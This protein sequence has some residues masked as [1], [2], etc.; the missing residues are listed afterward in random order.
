[1]ALVCAEFATNL[2]QTAE[3]PRTP[4]VASKGPMF[5]VPQPADSLRVPSGPATAAP[6]LV[7]S[8]PSTT[9]VLTHLSLG[10]NVYVD[11]HRLLTQPCI[12]TVPTLGFGTVVFWNGP[13]EVHA[14]RPHGP[15]QWV[16]VREVV[17]TLARFEAS[18][19]LQ[20]P[21]RVG[22]AVNVAAVVNAIV[23]GKASMKQLIVGQEA[24]FQSAQLFVK[25][26]INHASWVVKQHQAATTEVE[27]GPDH[28]AVPKALQDAWRVCCHAFGCS[29]PDL[30]PKWVF[31]VAR[32]RLEPIVGTTVHTMM[33][34]CHVSSKD[35][36]R[37]CPVLC[38]RSSTAKKLVLDSGMLEGM[39]EEVLEEE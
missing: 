15:N 36:K 2:V 17:S 11:I 32:S 6:V 26:F 3:M 23:D 8:S 27:V 13:A 1:M 29:Q 22:V 38:L 18:T 24:V 20:E 16:K 14:E 19:P 5:L 21:Q 28:A 9:L 12:G 31:A 34:L 35:I 39:V 37:P 33:Q 10:S 7:P 30:S 4:S 25:T